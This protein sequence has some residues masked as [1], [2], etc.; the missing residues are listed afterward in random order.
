MRFLASLA[1][2]TAAAAAICGIM[3]KVR[4]ASG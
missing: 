1:L 2:F 3:V 4:L